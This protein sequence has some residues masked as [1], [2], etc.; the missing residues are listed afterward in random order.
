MQV[1]TCRL[2]NQ[3]MPTVHVNLG[4]LRPV[5]HR[6][7][8]CA[9][10]TQ[11]G[12]IVRLNAKSSLSEFACKPKPNSLIQVEAKRTSEIAVEAAELLAAPILRSRL[13]R[14]LCHESANADH[15][16]D[17]TARRFPAESTH[18]NHLVHQQERI[19]AFKQLLPPG[20]ALYAI[21]GFVLA[22]CIS[23][24]RRARCLV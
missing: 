23:K 8:H 16:D 1:L 19:S 17:E 12:R 22:R 24:P 14:T 2:G 3:R 11:S 18:R 4:K 10:G 6:T 7:M 15:I 5:G 13:L 21:S 20:E 9:G